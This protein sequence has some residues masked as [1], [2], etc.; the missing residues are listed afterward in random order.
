MI[1]VLDDYHV[2][3]ALPIHQTLAFVLEHAPP[4][5][6]LVIATREDPLIAAG[7]PASPQ[8]ATELRGADLRFTTDEA[9]ISNQAMGLGLSGE[10][11]ARRWKAAPRAGSR[12]CNWPPS[13]CT[14]ARMPQ[15]SSS[16]SPAATGSCSTT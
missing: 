12:A 9:R 6:H 3:E 13:R 10:D 8:A 1:L 7:P 2:V 15:A 16:P 11:I 4:Q 14:G 5:L